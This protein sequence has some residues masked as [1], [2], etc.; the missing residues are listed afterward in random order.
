MNDSQSLERLVKKKTEGKLLLFKIA[1]IAGYVLFAVVGVLLAILLADG[2]PTLLV[3]VAALDFCLYICTWRL[4]QIEYEYSVVS[5]TLY[6]AKIFGKSAR[7]EI[8]E[9]EL[10]RAKT[11]APYSGQYKKDAEAAAPDKIYSVI[12]SKKTENLWFMLFE[13]ESEK[14]TMILF[15]ADEQALRVLRH[16]CPRAVAREK[17]AVTQ[18]ENK[19]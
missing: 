5:G 2:N 14:K 19:E 11:V 15:E 7:R 1:L 17:L 6:L 3:L 10:S 16:G 9:C 18:T 4:S 8:F 13:S 12:P